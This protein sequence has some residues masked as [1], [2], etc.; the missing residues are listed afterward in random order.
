MNR[1]VRIASLFISLFFILYSAYGV[2]YEINDK[3]KK[4]HDAI[5][6]MAGEYE[7]TFKFME[8]IAISKDYELKKPYL[9]E[10]TEIIFVVK[11]SPKNI[12]LQHVLWLE[13]LER[14]VKHWKQ[15]WKFEDQV[16]YEF[17]GNNTWQR[18]ELSAE[19]AS[20]TWTQKVYQVDDSPRYESYGKWHH[21]GGMSSWLGSKTQRP[22]PRRE[23][24]KRS[25]YQIMMAINRHTITPTGWVHEQDNFK[26]VSTTGEIL[27]R[28]VGLNNYQRTN[29]VDFTKAK[30]Y[31]AK[32][33]SYWG[34]VS[35][36]IDGK[37]EA[38]GPAFSLNK[39]IDG[40]PLYRAL[41]GLIKD[42]ADEELRK[43]K[44]KA[45]IL[46]FLKANKLDKSN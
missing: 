24:T 16:I 45:I 1:K 37:M 6:S 44:A 17:A 2:S 43:E 4:D 35:S 15:E 9:A 7:V 39:E 5:L 40:A 8:T 27:C 11:D 31:W 25:D 32:N 20:G 14:V 29:L 3:V 28:E 30:D 22:L 21:E 10:A 26:Q 34:F 41:F 36:I 23:Y 18:R 46:S 12:I 42:T 33:S 13:D 19:E 38:S